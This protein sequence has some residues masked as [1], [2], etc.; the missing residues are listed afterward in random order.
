MRPHVRLRTSDGGLVELAAGDFIGRSDRAALCINEPHISEAHAM[1]SLRSSELVLLALRGNLSVDGKPAARAALRAGQRIVLASR[2]AL[3]VEEVFLPKD[4]LTLAL[5]DGPPCVVASVCAIRLAP[6]PEIVA[7]F[8]PDADALVWSSGLRHFARVYGGPAVE[9]VAGSEL[10]VGDHVVHFA[11]VPIDAL[12]YAPTDHSYLVGAPLHLILNY[13]TVHIIS[14]PARVTLDGIIARIVSEL[15]AVRAPI[16]WQEVARLVWG[17]DAPSE[18]ALRER[19]DSNLAR[20]RRKL[21]DARIRGDL[22]HSTGGGHVELLLGP[23]DTLE[24]RM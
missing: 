4:V 9:V 19:W 21:K 5:D 20:L 1:V 3:D 11:D 7:G 23:G 18:A 17:A 15:A 24:D 13:D 2:T 10:A 16:A 8:A 6:E 22:V 12:S 14:G